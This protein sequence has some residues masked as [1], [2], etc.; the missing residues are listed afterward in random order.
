MR[1]A[2]NNSLL[3]YLLTYMTL[4]NDSYTTVT[5]FSLKQYTKHQ[6]NCFNCISKNNQENQIR[7]SN[8]TAKATFLKL[9]GDSYAAINQ[10]RQLPV[11]YSQLI[12]SEAI[13]FESLRRSAANGVVSSWW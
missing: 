9:R 7:R 8:F 4:H 5:Y 13:I 3:T 1:G 6:H 10:R 11:N 2:N 12:K